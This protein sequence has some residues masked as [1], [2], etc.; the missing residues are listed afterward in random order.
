MRLFG[1]SNKLEKKKMMKAQEET[2]KKRTKKDKLKKSMKKKPTQDGQSAKS[3]PFFRCDGFGPTI[4]EIRKMIFFLFFGWIRLFIDRC[5][6]NF[7]DI[8]EQ[9]VN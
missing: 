8:L 3:S 7:F 9:K 2:V 1:E 5:I 4:R 6:A